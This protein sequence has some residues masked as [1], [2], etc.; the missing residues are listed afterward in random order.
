M[1]M[2]SRESM[3]TGLGCCN[4]MS[5][6]SDTAAVRCGGDISQA[7]SMS[8]G[9][10]CCNKMSQNSDTAAVRCGGDIMFGVSLRYPAT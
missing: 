3:S 9:L 10:G 4:K 2:S 8:T 5:Q 7:I 1:F 6:N